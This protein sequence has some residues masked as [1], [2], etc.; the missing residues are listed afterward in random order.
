M[1]EK[2][3]KFYI[4]DSSHYKDDQMKRMLKLESISCSHDDAG[5]TVV[6]CG[7][8]SGLDIL[9]T[10]QTIHTGQDN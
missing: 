7:A 2:T 5:F 8:Q 3:T 9:T 6:V 10:D 1:A 4:L